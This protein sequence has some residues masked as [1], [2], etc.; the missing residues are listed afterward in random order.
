MAFL[1][2]FFPVLLF[3]AVYQWQGVFLATGALIVATLGQVAWTWF[4]KR[5]VKKMHLI[6]AILVLIFG[7]ITLLLQDEQFIKWKVSIVNWLFA[8]AFLASGFVGSRRTLIERML[9]AELEL[10]AAVWRRVNLGWVGFFTVLGFAN[11]YVMENF[12]TDT[13]V[14]FKLF[15]VL[16]LTLVFALLQGIYLAR[17]IETGED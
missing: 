13:W 10:P 5:E 4:R 12:D 3:F 15:G 7:G 6:T 14:D 11:W 1:Y 16:G 8:V 17:H 2:D 9:G